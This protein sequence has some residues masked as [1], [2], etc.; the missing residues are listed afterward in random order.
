MGAFE[1]EGMDETHLVRVERRDHEYEVNLRKQA[2]IMILEEV[3]KNF[4][5][6]ETSKG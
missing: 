6:S 2:L 4:L 1:D 3:G 5:Q